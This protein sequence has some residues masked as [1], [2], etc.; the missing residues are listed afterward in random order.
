MKTVKSTND[1]MVMEEIIGIVIK[2]GTTMVSEIVVCVV[3]CHEGRL[4]DH[5]E[6]EEQCSM[7]EELVVGLT[8]MI[9]G[10]VATG[11]VNTSVT[12]MKLIIDT[13]LPITIETTGIGIE[14]TVHI[15]TSED[16]HHPRE[17]IPIITTE[18]HPDTTLLET[19]RIDTRLAMIAVGVRQL[20][21]DLVGN[22]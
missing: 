19:A 21:A 6:Y 13:R 15:K 17:V 3:V 9:D 7:K 14:G 1:C 11:L 10:A 4:V 22:S 12:G 20:A 2:S 18:C 5:P 16:I 8:L